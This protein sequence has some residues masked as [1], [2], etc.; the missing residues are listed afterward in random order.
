MVGGGTGG[1]PGGCFSPCC[2]PLAVGDK[3]GKMANGASINS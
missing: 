3:D 2:T 1:D